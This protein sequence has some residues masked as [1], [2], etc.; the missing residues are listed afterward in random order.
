[1]SPLRERFLHDLQLAE[2]S[3]L[4]QK[5][6]VGVVADFARFSGNRDCEGG[7]RGMRNFLY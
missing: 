3:E 5:A 1:M 7:A 6:Y 2:R 4:T